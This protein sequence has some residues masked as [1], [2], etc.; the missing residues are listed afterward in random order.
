MAKLQGI[1][2][3]VGN[4]ISPLILIGSLLGC[5]VAWHVFVIVKDPLRSVPGPFWARFTRLW[6]LRQVARG[7]FEKTNVA[8]HKK[9]GTFFRRRSY[10]L[11]S[12]Y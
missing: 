2:S 1:L 10:M 11:E 12:K 7:D 8:L 4:G 9:H 3:E 6:Y 5:W